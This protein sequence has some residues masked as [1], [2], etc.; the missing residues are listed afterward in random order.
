MGLLSRARAPTILWGALAIALSGCAGAPSAAADREEPMRV[1]LQTEG[2][3]AHFP[4]LSRPM[5]IETDQLS[6]PEAAELRK[7]VDAARL[8]DKPAQVGTPTP[9]AADLRQYTITVE[10]GD[11][12]ETVRMTD[13]GDDPDLKRL[14][15]FLQDKAKALRAK[16]RGGSSP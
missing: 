8:S 2:G 9:G 10:S 15:R 3:I 1:T 13:L 16:A 5:T 7:L 14:L 6:A 4:G 12:S 11:R